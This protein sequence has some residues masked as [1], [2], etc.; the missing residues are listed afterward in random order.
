MNIIFD[1][2]SGQNKNNTVLRLGLAAWL[3]QMGYF[4]KVKFVFLIVGHTKNDTDRLFNSLK[5]EYRKENIFTMQ[6]LFDCLS[7]SDSVTVVPLVAEDFLD[8]NALFD[9]IYHPLAGKVKQ[10]HIFS[11]SGDNLLPVIELHASNLDEHQITYFK[12]L[13]KSRTVEEI[14]NLTVTWS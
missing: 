10:N 1:T 12:A 2:C 4:I 5:H 3:K 13:K 8:Y 9:D 6:A 7:V 14:S 11:C